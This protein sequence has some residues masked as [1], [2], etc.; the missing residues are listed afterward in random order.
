MLS[1]IEAVR[2]LRKKDSR[3]KVIF[4]SMHAEVELASQALRLGASGY[5]LKHAAADSPQRA[6]SRGIEGRDLCEPAHFR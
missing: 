6:I 3:T 5:V 2:Q 1:G 4:L